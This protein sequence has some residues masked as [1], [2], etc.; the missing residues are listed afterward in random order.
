MQLET[1]S[2]C[3][4]LLKDVWDCNL[5]LSSKIFLV[6]AE[7][8]SINRSPVNSTYK[9]KSAADLDGATL[10]AFLACLI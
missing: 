7:I 4:S 6:L 9:F 1:A 3:P 5:V 10:K 2:F 8:L